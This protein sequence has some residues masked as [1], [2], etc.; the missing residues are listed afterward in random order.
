MCSLSAL[1]G[2]GCAVVGGSNWGSIRLSAVWRWGRD[3][4]R[5]GVQRWIR[6]VR[7]GGGCGWTSGRRRAASG[8]Q[9][10]FLVRVV[11]SVERGGGSGW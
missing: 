6:R 11:A 3:G 7:E 2:S 10:W 1:V 8:E 5:E 9:G 4:G